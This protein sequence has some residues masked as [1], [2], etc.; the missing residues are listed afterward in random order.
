MKYH[1]LASL[2][3]EALLS[4]GFFETYG[5]CFCKKSTLPKKEPTYGE[6]GAHFKYS[7]LF[8]KL[9]DLFTSLPKE[10]IGYNGML[11]Q[12]QTKS[13]TETLTNN[14][15]TNIPL[16]ILIENS[17]YSKQILKSRNFIS[18]HNKNLFKKKLAC[19][20]N[21]SGE[22]TKTYNNKTNKLS[23][24]T[25]GTLLTSRNIYP[26]FNL[27]QTPILLRKNKEMFNNEQQGCLLRKTFYSNKKQCRSNNKGNNYVFESPVKYNKNAFGKNSLTI[28]YTHLNNNNNNVYLNTNMRRV[29]T[30]FNKS[31]DF[32]CN[33]DVKGR[34][35]YINFLEKS[36]QIKGNKHSK[37]KSN[38]L[39][40]SSNKPTKEKSHT[41]FPFY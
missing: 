8:S 2:P 18:Q 27:K 1:R 32:V 41:F 26:C 33:S 17:T 10:R 12:E 21:L 7:D 28:K 35:T 37:T 38:M 4:E 14:I 39:T 34:S 30:P 22:N 5:S 20:S 29:V 24:L 31:N 36:T 16:P 15:N 25:K 19:L 6:H 23:P 3:N 13:N 11:F 40:L 9:L